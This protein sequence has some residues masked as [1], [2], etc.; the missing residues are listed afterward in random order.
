[1]E[2]SNFIYCWSDHSSTVRDQPDGGVYNAACCNSNR[3][4][5][6]PGENAKRFYL[7]FVISKPSNLCSRV[8]SGK[9]KRNCNLVNS[10]KGKKGDLELWRKLASI[11]P[12][13]VENVAWEVGNGDLTD[14]WNDRWIEGNGRLLEKSVGLPEDERGVK[15]V[16][17]RRRGPEFWYARRAFLNSYHLTCDD[18]ANDDDDAT[19]SWKQ[20][21]R[22]RVKRLH[23]KAMS[24]V[25]FKPFRLSYLAPFS[26]FRPSFNSNTPTRHPPLVI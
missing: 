1:M 18:N 7:G 11:W 15:Q 22:V 2:I 24:L 3:S 8:L 19:L 16:G 23:H 20:K 12:S 17:E 13:I 26:C 9:Y 10:C 21:L 14:F 25:H 6:T 4:E 5:T